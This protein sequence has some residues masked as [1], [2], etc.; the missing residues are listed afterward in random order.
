MLCVKLFSV[1]RAVLPVLCLFLAP[2]PIAAQSARPS[3]INNPYGNF[4]R[5]AYIVAVGIGNSRRAAE[6]DA[7]RGIAST[8]ELNIRATEQITTLY[9]EVIENGATNWTQQTNLRSTIESSVRV[10]NLIGAGVRQHWPDGRGNHYVL[11]VL[12]KARSVGLYSSRIE[13][14]QDVIRN[15]TNMPERNSID[16]FARY[17]LAAAIADMN[18]IYGE[19]LVSLNPDAAWYEVLAGGEYFRQRAGQIARSIPIDIN[20]RS[21]NAITDAR[22]RGAFAEVLF[23][24]VGFLTGGTNHRYVLDVEVTMHPETRGGSSNFSSR[25]PSLPQLIIISVG[26]SARLI[27]SNTGVVLLPFYLNFD[28]PRHFDESEAERIAINQTVQR[29]QNEYGK[30]LSRLV[31]RQ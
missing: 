23:N 17:Q 5:K 27:D 16:G 8:L 21:G 4:N 12:N 3:W 15:L 11:A 9:W 7:L 13:A 25:L 30:R 10:D 31:P 6:M 28:N 19:A 2:A 29:I 1:F 24:E 20:V 22:I 26:V 18:F 14:N